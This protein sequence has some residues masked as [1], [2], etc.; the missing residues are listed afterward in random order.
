MAERLDLSG[1]SVPEERVVRSMFSILEDEFEM[2][3]RYVEPTPENLETYSAQF[4][5]LHQDACREID[6]LFKLKLKQ[7][8]LWPTTKAG[9][10][11]QEVSFKHYYPLK[12]KLMLEN[13]EVRLLNRDIKC[14]PYSDWRESKAPKWW[15]DHNLLK[16]DRINN[17][18][19]A[20]LENAVQ[21]LA[22][23]YLLLDDFRIR[24]HSPTPTKIFDPLF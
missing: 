22:A 14:S 7:Y 3:C 4:Y 8:N 23:L 16:H 20:T 11:L 15:S 17:F 6:T 2:C 19:K 9:K 12:G 5:R 18:K 1:T 24:I 10:K 13:K 21:S